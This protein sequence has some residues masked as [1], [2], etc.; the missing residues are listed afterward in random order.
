MPAGLNCAIQGLRLVYS[1]DEVGGSY[2]TGTILHTWVDARIDEN[3]PDPNMIGQGL[4]TIKTFSALFWGNN[5]RLQEQD[6]VVV[7]SPPNHQYY[8]Q[9][10][11]IMHIRG[12]SRHPDIKQGYRTAILTRSQ[13]AHRNPFQ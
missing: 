1:D 7:I 11:R 9:T 12:D 4:E 13:K 3:A 2:P 10:F 6:E 8:N 5:L